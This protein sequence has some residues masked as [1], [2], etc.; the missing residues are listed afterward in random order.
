MRTDAGIGGREGSRYRKQCQSR[1]AG[2]ER[3][4][5]RFRRVFRAVGFNDRSERVFG[6]A[7]FA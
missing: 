6:M 7:G 3:D 2:D 4:S 1:E 5:A